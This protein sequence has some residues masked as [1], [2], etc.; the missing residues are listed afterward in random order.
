MTQV[1]SFQIYKDEIE[2][3]R[4]QNRVEC[5]LYSIVACIIRSSK[6]GSNISLRDVSARRKSKCSKPFEGESGFPDFVIMAREKT[7]DAA[8]LGA[9]EV[10]YVDKDLD[11]SLEQLQGHRS[12]FNHVI[13]TNGL[14]WRLYNSNDSE[15]EW[16]IFLGKRDNA[17]IKWGDV[18]EWC[19]LL[20]NIDQINWM[21][22]GIR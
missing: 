16:R 3:I 19:C 2:L 5:E 13:Y 15:N 14:E 7:I 17:G 20:K 11:R 21:S 4:S 8:V 1:D 6:Q 9:I 12:S 22:N 10:K 18:S